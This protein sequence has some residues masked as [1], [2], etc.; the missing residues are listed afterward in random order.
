MQDLSINLRDW[1]VVIAFLYFYI[2]NCFKFT[3]IK[4]WIRKS[5]IVNIIFQKFKYFVFWGLNLGHPQIDTYEVPGGC[6]CDFQKIADIQTEMKFWWMSS[7][8][9]CSSSWCICPFTTHKERIMTK[10]LGVCIGLTFQGV[11][12]NTWL[13]IPK[14]FHKNIWVTCATTH[15]KHY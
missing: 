12:K 2:K 11:V 14:K 10:I 13:L 8:Q 5:M 9:Q 4:R 6:D 3:S 15:N 1:V 7:C